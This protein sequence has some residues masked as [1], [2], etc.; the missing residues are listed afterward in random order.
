MKIRRRTITMWQYSRDTKM[1]AHATEAAKRAIKKKSSW[2]V[3]TDV[4]YLAIHVVQQLGVD[5]LRGRQNIAG[6]R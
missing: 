5:E 6:Y 3:D 1:F 4:G 2:P